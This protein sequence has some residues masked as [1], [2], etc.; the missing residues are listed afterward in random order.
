MYFYV[1]NSVRTKSGKTHKG[2][3]VFK[4]KNFPL[5][6]KKDNLL[7]NIILKYIKQ[8]PLETEEK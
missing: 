5:K 8:K 7:N 6:Y 3:E 2:I 4:G 1:N